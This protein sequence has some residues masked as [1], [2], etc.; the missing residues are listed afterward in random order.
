MT[1][2]SK[3]QVEVVIDESLV[4]ALLQEQH[5][6]LAHLPLDAAGEGWD[7]R[8]FRLGDDLVVRL[9]RRAIAAALIERELRWLPLLSPRLPLPIPV[10]LRGGQPGCGYPWAWSITSWFPGD[11]ALRAPLQELR[12][13][14]R[15]LGH[16]LRELHHPAPEHAPFNPWRSVP[17]TARSAVFTKH[18]EQVGGLVDRIAAIDLWERACAAP[19]WPGPPLWIHGDLHL[20]N[21]VVRDGVLSAVI[22]FGDLAAGDPATDLSVMWMLLPVPLRSELRESARGEF[23]PVDDHTVLRARGWALALG[24]AYLA[25]SRGDEA[26]GTLGLATINAALSDG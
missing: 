19:V 13:A 23:D 16:F 11:T 14:A 15:V 5:E 7:N 20:D 2:G 6:D 9:P 18:L 17:L 3:P 26:M 12:A 8:L 1:I 25:D 22:D 4:R 21:L 10:P 24:L